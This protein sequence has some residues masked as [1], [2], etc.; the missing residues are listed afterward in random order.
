MS[1][2]RAYVLNRDEKVKASEFVI[3]SMEPI[4]WKSII[5]QVMQSGLSMRK[6]AVTI[7]V[8]QPTVQG[9]YKGSIP[10]Y[11]SG[12]KLLAMAAVARK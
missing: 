6:I 1:L 4:N 5:D 11:D 2:Y 9:W 8:S 12:R 10:S 7:N 3:D